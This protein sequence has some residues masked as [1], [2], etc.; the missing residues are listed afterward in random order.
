M[1]EYPDQIFD[2]IVKICKP[3]VTNEKYK[4][5]QSIAPFLALHGEL[6][7]KER[8]NLLTKVDVGELTLHEM[9]N[10][11][12]DIKIVKF[13]KD[14]FAERVGMEWK[15]CLTVFP[16]VAHPNWAQTWVSSFKMAGPSNNSK[17]PA[18]PV[19]FLNWIRDIKQKG[20][21]QQV[22]EKELIETIRF[23]NNSYHFWQMD[24]VAIRQQIG[25]YPA[26]SKFFN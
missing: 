8:I 17:K 4:L 22:L 7:D 6:T 15:D 20:L 9:K 23:S 26:P 18:I 10:K 14:T 12:R 25:K 2:L 11:A 24:V 5:P 21:Q 3:S 1:A 13:I 16:I 19:T